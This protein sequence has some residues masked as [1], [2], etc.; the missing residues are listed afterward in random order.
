VTERTRN[1]DAIYRGAHRFE[2]NGVGANYLYKKY[3]G[4]ECPDIAAQ[5]VD[6]GG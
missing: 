2:A 5:V 1:S 4:T 6:E 3:L